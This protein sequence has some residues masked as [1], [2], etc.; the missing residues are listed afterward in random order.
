VPRAFSARRGFTL[1]ELLVVIAII[2][3]LISLLVP[4]VQKVRAAAARLQCTNNMKQLGLAVHGFHDSYKAFPWDG[5]LW[6]WQVRG[7]IEQQGASSD[8]YLAVLY[9]PSEPRGDMGGYAGSMTWYVGTNSLNYQ[10]DGIL[11]DGSSSSTWS[12]TKNIRIHM[13]Q[14]TDG[15]SNT[16][17]IAERPPDAPDLWGFWDYESEDIWWDDTRAPVKRTQL[18]YTH[19]EGANNDPPCP[20]PALPQWWNA[21]NWCAFNV[22]WSN[23]PGGLNV[24][25][26]DGSVRFMTYSAGNALATSLSGQTVFQALATRA[27]AETFSPPDE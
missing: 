25:M 27:G 11:V 21:M 17:M 20:N 2:A 15:M 5:G 14:V 3:I 7:Y 22:V 16:M 18:F 9:C 8:N 24:Q 10:P 12:N 23:H 4:S 26:G 13:T 19:N 6:I 1:I